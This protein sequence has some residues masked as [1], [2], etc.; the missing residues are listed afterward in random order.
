MIRIKGYTEDEIKYI[1]DNYK[2]RTNKEIGD[3]LGKKADSISYVAQKIG[4]VKQPHKP[5]TLDEENYLRNNY[6]NMKSEEI[7]KVLGRTVPS[8]NARCKDLNLIKHDSWSDNEIDYL[9][10]HYMS[11]EHREI[12]E[13]LGRSE[14]AIRAKCFDLN[15]YKKELPWTK[16][17]IEFVKNNYVE[18]SVNE[19][20]E[21]LS[22][23]PNA[24]KLKAERMGMKKSPYYCDYHFFDNIDSEE[25]AYWLG[26]I[27]ADGWVNK[28]EGSQSGTVG[29][30]LQ[31][32]D[33]KHLKKFNKSINGN[34]RITDRWRKCSLS[35]NKNKLNH[36]CCIRVFS[37]IMYKALD[38][39]GI[40]G[41]KTYTCAFPKIRQDLYR[42]YIRGLFDADG[43]FCLS[44][45]S[46]GVSYITASENL[47]NDFIKHMKLNDIEIFDY[48]YIS[49]F[50]TVM[51]RPTINKI[52]EMIKFLDWIYQDSSIYLDRK[53]K[54]YLKAK[55][56]YGTS[57]GLAAQK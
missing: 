31:Y 14:S 23:S 37:M 50:D 52:T 53:Y 29:I 56:K 28:H 18:M 34:Y 39:L 26:F 25:K 12:G 9:L 42:H 10:K 32:G 49:E 44:N 24:V 6:M 2:D 57:N 43:C 13:F 7:A 33:I 4:L 35:N 5:W 36:M 27:T 30:E 46:F 38:A 47:K 55:E 40:S 22:R 19:I 3:Y 21:I 51:Y 16:D 11:M 17:E 15:L 54:K 1:Q 45:K 8:I 20:S 48:S 41:N